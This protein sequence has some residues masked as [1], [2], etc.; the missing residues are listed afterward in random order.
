MKWLAI[1]LTILMSCSIAT[2]DSVKGTV[3]AAGTPGLSEAVVYIDAIPG[4]DF[5]PPAAHVTIDQIDL[6]YKPHVLAILVGTT[7]DFHNGD[8]MIHNVFTADK[9]ADAFNL[10]N[11]GK[12]ESR[13]H[14]FTKP[15]VAGL[16]CAFHPDMEAFVVTAPTPYFAVTDGSGGFVINDVPEGSYTLKAWHDKMKDL[17]QEIKVQGETAVTLTFGK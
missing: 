12:G 13:S 4:K 5:P 11:F 17:S 8:D 9:C 15:C 10:G 14:T 3:K 6:Q 1:S 7:V 16:L 2:A